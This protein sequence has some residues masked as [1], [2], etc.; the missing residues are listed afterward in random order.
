MDVVD[1]LK[2]LD[3][4]P[5][6]SAAAVKRAYR[7]MLMV[8]HPDR[9]EDGS[10]LQE[11]ATEKTRQVQLAYELLQTEGTE[12]FRSQQKRGRSKPNTE[13]GDRANA[14]D[15]SSPRG[16]S[17][18]AKQGTDRSSLVGVIF[19]L[20][21]F[22]FIALLTRSDPQSNQA[23]EGP[24]LPVRVPDTGAPGAL[25]DG[26][27]SE[28][29]ST[30]MQGQRLPSEGEVRAY[31]DSITSEREDSVS[32]PDEL[33]AP[34]VGHA[35]D[36]PP[37][38]DEIWVGSTKDDVLAVMGNPSTMGSTMWWYES[39]YISFDYSDR[40]DGYSDDGNLQ[41]R[42]SHGLEKPSDDC[43]SAQSA[44]NDVLAVMGNPST[45]GSTMWWYGSSYVT[46]DFSGEV[47]GFSNDG[48]LKL[49]DP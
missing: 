13:S 42:T 11:K 23:P 10:E 24:D 41:L 48:N 47:D 44:K 4:E 22:G 9:F 38:S 20:A 34:A 29:S 39:S 7:E 17:T 46:F 21:I 45:M 43:I 14:K 25:T 8:W 26:L 40:V 16:S 49:C 33:Q 37:P 3:L 35:D 32:G 19:L 28:E 36:D 27:P 6:A 12:T 5:G 18:E 1:A 15:S 31:L 30:V 2:I